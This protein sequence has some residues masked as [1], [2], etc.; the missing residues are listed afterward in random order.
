[1]TSHPSAVDLVGSVDRDVKGSELVELL[2]G[3]SQL[4]GEQFGRR[5][6]RGA[7]QAEPARRKRRQQMRDG[8][9]GAQADSL[10]LDHERRGG[11][12]RRSLLVL[13]VV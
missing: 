12:R 2:D 3:E 9:S 5:R 8:R 10:P 4:F 7:M 11:L 6:G 1:M 13:A